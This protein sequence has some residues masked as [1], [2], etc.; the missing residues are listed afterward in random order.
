MTKGYTLEHM[1]KQMK[2]NW[3][4]ATSLE[5]ELFLSMNRFSEVLDQNCAQNLEEFGLTNGAF[6]ALVALRAQPE[7]RQLSPSELYRSLM[8]TSGCMTKILK[9]READGLI[10][11]VD[12][13]T[14]KRSKMVQLTEKGKD[15]AERAMERVKEG[16]RKVIYE[17][18]TKEEVLT[19]H[20]TLMNVVN[21]LGV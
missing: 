11:R 20:D 18:L 19:L 21:K 17:N 3:P 2:Q 6:E 16:D 14:D 15:L 13:K 7:P 5:A 12:H 10:D 1:L 8:L 4:E 9:Q